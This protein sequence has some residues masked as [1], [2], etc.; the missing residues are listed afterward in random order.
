MLNTIKIG[1]GGKL[2]P[3]LTITADGVGANSTSATRTFGGKTVSLNQPYAARDGQQLWVFEGGTLTV[4]N[5]RLQG[6]HLLK[7][8]F[9]RGSGGL[10][11]KITGGFARED[12][13]GAIVLGSTT[14]SKGSV[15]VLSTRQVGSSC[16]VS[17]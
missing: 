12:G 8:T 1:A 5:T 13:A 10:T 17:K 4:M 7:I 9:S 14:H 3:S 6:G 2:T 16:R 15:E 11:C